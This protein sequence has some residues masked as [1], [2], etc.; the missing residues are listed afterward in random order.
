MPFYRRSWTPTNDGAGS[1]LDADLLDGL[2]SATANTPS[3]VVVRDASGNFSAGTV[4]TAQAVV[5]PFF[6]N[7]ATISVNYTIPVGYNSVAA[8]PVTVA[9]GVVVTVS[10]GSMW[11]IV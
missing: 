1:G 10:D 9:N 3:T 5:S 7:N 4:T 11:T 2:N 8:G 6:V